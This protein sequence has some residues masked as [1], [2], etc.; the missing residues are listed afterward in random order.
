MRACWLAGGS[1][2]LIGTWGHSDNTILL[3]LAVPGSHARPHVGRGP[4]EMANTLIAWGNNMLYMVDHINNILD[5][6]TK[7]PHKRV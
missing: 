3:A 7:Q 1:R 5:I 6:D 4:T 2:C